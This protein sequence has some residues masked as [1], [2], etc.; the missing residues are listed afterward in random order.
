MTRN[1]FKVGTFNVYN[2]ISANVAYYG[3]KKYKPEV[4]DKKVQ[5]IG[6]QLDRMNADLVGFQEV[7]QEKALQDAI[8]KS[9]YL[10]GSKIIVAREMGNSPS[11]AIA[12]KLPVINHQVIEAFPESAQLH[13]EGEELALKRFSRP[14]LCVQVELRKGIECTF[15][16]AHLKSKRP[17]LAEGAD[18]DDP[19]EEAKG[20]VRS[21]I[22][23][24]A[25]SV[26]LRS[27][28]LDVLKDRTHPVIAVGDL[29][30]DSQAVTTRLISGEPPWRKLSAA[31]KVPIW[32][33]L[34]HHV[35]DI[36]ARKSYEN[37]YYTH[38]YNGHYDSLDH[39]LVSQEF[40]DLNR[41]RI[42]VVEYVSVFNDHLIDETLS[43]EDVEPWQ[44]DHGQVVASI[45]LEKPKK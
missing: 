13:I 31:R 4:Y 34:M 28:L 19:L 17:D 39:I 25:E 6:A 9:E 29:N 5:W 40:A 38:I 42:G 18:K 11:V 16:V 37:F 30:D 35:K 14:I 2:L 8:D 45:E 36:Q 12:S 10:Q 44:S 32:D 22:R 3:N 27:V 43:K 23:R 21:L 24:A 15:V 1:R 26:A 41:D 7:W 20:K 33:V